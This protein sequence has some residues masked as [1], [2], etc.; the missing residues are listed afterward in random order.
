LLLALVALAKCHTRWNELADYSFE[1]YIVEYSKTY[2]GDELYSR[3][4]LFEASLSK[5]SEHNKDSS[6]TYKL[7]INHLSDWSEKELKQLLGYKKSSETIA[8]INKRAKTSSLENHLLK[9]TLPTGVDWRAK[10]VISPVKDQG[11]CGSCWTFGTAAT[12][13]SF[14]AL[15]TGELA[16]QSVQ[17]ILDCT[18][19]PKHC[20]GTGGCGGGTP[21]LAYDQIIKDGGLSSEWTYPYVSYFG[22]DF[23]TCKASNTTRYAAKIAS[24]V[25]LPANEYE[26][27]INALATVGPLAINVDAGSWFSYES[28][29]FSGCNATEIVIDHVVQLVGYGTDESLGD[30]WIVRNSWSPTWGEAGYIRIKRSATKQCGLDHSPLEGTGCDGGPSVITVCGECGILFDVSYPLVA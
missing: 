12:I 9:Y 5:V 21:E 24:Y 8:N 2:S 4:A 15:K 1:K 28:G 6:K 17:Q 20:G 11:M 22:Q 3:K 29:V 10:G 23:P 14:H 13:E 18:P 27:V 25:V 26:P 16:E 19:N 30:Y 7:G